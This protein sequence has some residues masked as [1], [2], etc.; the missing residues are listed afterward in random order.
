MHIPLLVLYLAGVGV[1]AEGG[2]NAGDSCKGMQGDYGQVMSHFI[3]LDEYEMEMRMV[4]WELFCKQLNASKPMPL[5][6][7]HIAWRNF[8]SFLPL[9]E[10]NCDSFELA[11]SAEASNLTRLCVDITELNAIVLALGWLLLRTCYQR[12]YKPAE[13][14]NDVRLTFT[15][16]GVDEP[17][18]VRNSM[19]DINH[20]TQL[21]R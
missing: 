14:E 10:C 20:R 16:K 8:S 5:G 19:Y 11:A 3:F 18:F 1:L 17:T 21:Q 9:N 6:E 7:L 2:E 15:S 12:F 4:E 13:G